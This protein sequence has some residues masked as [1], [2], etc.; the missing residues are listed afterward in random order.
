MISPMQTGASP[1]E[2]RPHGAI[3]DL[4]R[5]RPG[6]WRHCSRW[7]SA[8]VL[9]PLWLGWVFGNLGHLQI[10]ATLDAHEQA[11]SLV[12]LLRAHLG[13]DML[14]Q[15]DLVVSIEG[16]ACDCT[17]P[18]DAARW[19]TAVEALGEHHVT[20]AVPGAAFSTLVF[21]TAGALRF[22]GSPAAAGCTGD[23]TRL[24]SSVT[25]PSAAPSAPFVSACVC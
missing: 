19:H 23:P 18:G 14:A 25:Q 13:A 2:A 16:H 10:A 21:D 8:F 17:S 22:A 20:V 5:P 6:R 11:R 1:V 12:S 9:L 24:L 4:Q 3:I 15:G 7:C